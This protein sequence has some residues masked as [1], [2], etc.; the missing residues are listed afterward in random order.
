MTEQKPKLGRLDRRQLLKALSISAA[1]GAAGLGTLLSSRRGAAQTEKKPKFLIVIGGVGGCSLI[2]SFLA[3]RTSEAGANAANVNCYPDQDVQAIADSPF[4]ALDLSR[5][6]T[7]AIPIPFTANQSSFVRRNKDDLMVVTQT[8]TSV[9]HTVAQKRSLTGNE[10]WAGR[11]LQEAVANEYGAAFPLPNVNMAIDGYIQHGTDRSLPS[12]CYNEPVANA[13]LW[14]LS[15]DGAKGLKDLPSRERLDLAR[16]LRDEKLDPESRFVRTFA[17]S[18]R[19]ELWQEQ[20]Q[21][22]GRLEALDLITKLNIFPN[23][24]P[25]IPL[26]E[27][28]LGESPEGA[29]LRTAFPRFLTDPFEAQ[30][31]LAFLLIKYRVSCAVTISPSFNVLLETNAFPPA[32]V[33]PPLAFDFSHNSH[34]AAQAVGWSRLLSVADRLITLLK[35]EEFEA[36]QSL[37]DRSLIYIAT[38]FGRS[39]R[40]PANADDFGTSHDLNNG[41]AI[42]SPFAN[43][44][45]VLGGVDPTTGLTYGFDPE[46]PS[47]VP[48]PATTMTER[49]VFAG[50]LHALDVDTS[51][52]GLPNM[53]AMRKNA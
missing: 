2:D 30:A 45:K 18:P 28:G 31:A 15:L 5:R 22:Q 11:T 47:G 26:A 17:A 6:Q 23:R 10:A 12:Y 24:P 35:S 16:K 9:N 25:Q 48:A 3:I 50:L 32:V 14:P 37:W 43:G 46:D 19:L 42:I 4:R 29:R 13:A 53:R 40:R 34:R 44:N 21:A 8:G 36:G 20:R 49:H 27:Y 52:S 7:G 51:G 38:E 1:G 41:F 39:K 33:N